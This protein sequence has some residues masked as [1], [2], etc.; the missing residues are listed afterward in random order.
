MTEDKP[1]QPAPRPTM[2]GGIAA[3]IMC[4]PL[5]CLGLFI[6]LQFTGLNDLINRIR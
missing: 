3:G 6:D 5:C 2:P 4:V 1:G